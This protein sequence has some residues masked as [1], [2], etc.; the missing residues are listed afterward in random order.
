MYIAEA[1]ETK[2]QGKGKDD[3]KPEEEEVIIW[4]MIWII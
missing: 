1:A 3:D 2:G 4:Y